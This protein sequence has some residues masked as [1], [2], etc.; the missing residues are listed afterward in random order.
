MSSPKKNSSIFE[1]ADPA[2]ESGDSETC[3]ALVRELQDLQQKEEIELNATRPPGQTFTDGA[4]R[5]IAEYPAGEKYQAAALTGTARDTGEIA[6][7]HSRLQARQD[8]MYVLIQS[9][10]AR[11]KAEAEREARDAAPGLAAKAVESLDASIDEVL[12]AIEVLEETRARLQDSFDTIARSRELNAECAPLTLDQFHRAGIALSYV[13]PRRHAY[14]ETHGMS[15]R[16]RK[17]M[18]LFGSTMAA[19][20][21]ARILVEPPTSVL[22]TIRRNVQPYQARERLEHEKVIAWRDELVMLLGS[23]SLDDDVAAL[24]AATTEDQSGATAA[25]P[26]ALQ[27]DA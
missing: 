27:V 1:R 4:G 3:H 8:Q 9:L 25:P 24:A 5:T 17:V 14:E 15:R 21:Y 26:P 10:G 22:D 6:A 23:T 2:L 18:P 7:E 16:A 13:M 12:A 19:Q 11:A 20:R